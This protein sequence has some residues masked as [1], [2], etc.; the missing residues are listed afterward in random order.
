MAPIGA[1]RDMYLDENG[2]VD[3]HRA[4]FSHLSSGVPGT[5][6]G[7]YKAHSEFGRLPWKRLLQPAIQQ[8]RDGIAMTYDLAGLLRRGK[9]RLCREEAPAV[10]STRMAVSRTSRASYG[11]RKISRPRSNVLPKMVLQDSIPGRLPG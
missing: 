10:I 7:L 3:N 11:F 9:D 2:D 6:A 5:V 4:R 1:T 8:A